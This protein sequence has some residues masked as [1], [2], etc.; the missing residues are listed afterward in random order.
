MYDCGG[1]I[2]GNDT[3]EE[4]HCLH[5]GVDRRRSTTT[6]RHIGISVSVS[7]SMPRILPGPRL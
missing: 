7:A 4:V 5:T 6:P 2:L 3:L 1:G